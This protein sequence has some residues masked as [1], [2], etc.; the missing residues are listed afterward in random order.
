M[1]SSLPCEMIELHARCG[2][3]LIRLAQ[4]LVT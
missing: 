1:E 4:R 2:M 3:L